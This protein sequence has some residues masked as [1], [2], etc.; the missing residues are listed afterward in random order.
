M[1]LVCSGAV[2][3][4]AEGNADLAVHMVVKSFNVWYP[5]TQ[6]PEA[7]CLA[8][9]AKKDD[10][11]VSSFL[12]GPPES[13]SGIGS[14][15]VVAAPVVRD[16]P[17]AYTQ[18]HTSTSADTA[19]TASHT[20]PGSTVPGGDG[21]AK[22]NGLSAAVQRTR[23][24]SRSGDFVQ[25]AHSLFLAADLEGQSFA[26]L[27]GPFPLPIVFCTYRLAVKSS[28]TSE[29]APHT[30]LAGVILRLSPVTEAKR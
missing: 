23:R 12:F 25:C 8:A 10:G 11:N 14:L 19:S 9:P 16:I 18:T 17:A 1:H 3:A 26:R 20:Y 21:T 4:Q 30:T 27:H 7:K 6:K 15:I 5:F 24:K 28:N 2:R 22:G 13:K 29:T